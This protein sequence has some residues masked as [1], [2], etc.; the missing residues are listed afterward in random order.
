MTYTKYKSDRCF[1]SFRFS[2]CHSV[3]RHGIQISFWI[4]FCKGMTRKMTSQSLAAN[5]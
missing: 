2:F 4:P 3:R 5:R 1:L